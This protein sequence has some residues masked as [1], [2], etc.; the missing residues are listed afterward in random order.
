MRLKLS[1]KIKATNIG[2][3]SLVMPRPRVGEFHA[4]GYDRWQGSSFQMP[5]P[6]V[7]EFHAS[8]YIAMIVRLPVTRSGHLQVSGRFP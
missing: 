4:A 7:G 6:R 3:F 8:S 5:R 1:Q 2:A